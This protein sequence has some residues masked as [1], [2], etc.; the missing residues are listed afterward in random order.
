MDSR[1]KLFAFYIVDLKCIC[2][3]KVTSDTSILNMI[4]F[5]IISEIHKLVQIKSI[6]WIH[7]VWLLFLD[8]VT[9]FF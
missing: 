3:Y 1:S 2:M 9:L 5:N 6:Y 8:G 7:M 4:S